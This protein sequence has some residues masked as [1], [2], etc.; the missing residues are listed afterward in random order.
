MAEIL[1]RKSREIGH[2]I[3]VISDEPY[4]ELVYDGVQ[5]PYIPKFY[6]D[7]VVVYSYSKSSPFPGSGSAIWQ[8]PAR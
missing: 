1:E 3:L 2:P 6:K 8:S 7:T 4:R 5:V